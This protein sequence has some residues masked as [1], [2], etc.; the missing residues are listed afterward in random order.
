M[1]LRRHDPVPRAHT[2]AAEPV[3]LLHFPA[4]GL[5]VGVAAHQFA[6]HGDQLGIVQR[7]AEVR[8]R[9]SIYFLLAGVGRLGGGWNGEYDAVHSR[10]E[11][12]VRPIGKEVADVDQ[13]G[14]R[15]VVVGL[16]LCACIS[17][18]LSHARI[19][20][21]GEGIAPGHRSTHVR[22]DKN[23]FPLAL[24]GQNLESGLASLL[25]QQ[26][27]AAVV[28]V[29]TRSNIDGFFKIEPLGIVCFCIRPVRRTR[30]FWLLRPS[31]ITLLV[32]VL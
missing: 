10:F 21:G 11:Q 5:V 26:R 23:T 2:A 24:P 31:N 30:H 8:H 16:I 1:F 27:D 6:R 12:A 13:D 28:A 29:G 32:Q 4:R 17:D 20:H 18:C 3:D 22:V 19:S 25:E 15:S 7:M 14:W 9:I